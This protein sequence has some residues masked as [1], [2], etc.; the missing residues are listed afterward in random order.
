M[1]G[2][3]P[4]VVEN[5]VSRAAGIET[6][7]YREGNP[8]S[9]ASTSCPWNL[10]LGLRGSTPANHVSRAAGNEDYLLIIEGVCR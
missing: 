8:A 5:H 6:Y 9:L 7:E 3:E 2:E 1:F 4:V 10:G